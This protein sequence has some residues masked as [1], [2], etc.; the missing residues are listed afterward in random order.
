[1]FLFAVECKKDATCVNNG[2]GKDKCDG[3]SNTCGECHCSQTGKYAER[4]MSSFW[5]QMWH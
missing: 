1:M 4:Q 2:K 3:F 5:H